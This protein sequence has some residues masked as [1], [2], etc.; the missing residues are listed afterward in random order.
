MTPARDPP[1][2]CV[3]SRE[4]LRCRSHPSRAVVR[5]SV[6]GFCIHV[7]YGSAAIPYSEGG[8]QGGAGI[9][10]GILE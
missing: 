7:Q 1:Q 4:C 2:T 3:V 6:T 5:G 8:P 9:T 10:L